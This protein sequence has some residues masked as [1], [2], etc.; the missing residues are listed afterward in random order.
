[1]SR[2]YVHGPSNGVTV[3][4]NTFSSCH[5]VTCDEPEVEAVQYHLTL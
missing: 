3:T 4:E 5:G 1:M 2:I